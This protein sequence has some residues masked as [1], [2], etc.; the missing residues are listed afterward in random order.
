MQ[1][2]HD[3]TVGGFEVRNVRQNYIFSGP[4][5]HLGEVRSGD[6]WFPCW[7]EEDGTCG[8]PDYN[9]VP[10]DVTRRVGHFEIPNEA[11]AMDT[12]A[13]PPGTPLVRVVWLNG[14][15]Q[16]VTLCSA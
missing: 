8:L 15:P 4:T 9:L 14:K 12:C 3:V 10:I 16:E 7:W 6:L 2:F 5:I 13:F 1:K 11:T